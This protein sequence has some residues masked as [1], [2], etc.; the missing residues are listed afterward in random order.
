MWPTNSRASATEPAPP[1]DPRGLEAMEKSSDAYRTISEAA[2]ELDLPQHVLRFWETRFPQ[3]RPLKRGGG[4][5]F[6]RPDDLDLLRAIRHLLYGE[7]YTIRGVQKMLKEQGP[8][9]VIAQAL[10]TGG[11]EGVRVAASAAAS[12]AP[13]PEIYVDEEEDAE[14]DVAPAP[15]PMLR[16][17]PPLFAQTPVTAPAPAPVTAP[18]PIPSPVAVSAPAPSL[19]LFHPDPEPESLRRPVGA[20]APAPATSYAPPGLVLGA[21]DLRRLESALAELE[22]CR[23]LLSAA[24]A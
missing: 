4:R 15:A 9:G 20:V 18:A 10:A 3:V 21:E 14:P 22:E 16:E 7:G 13:D 11:G 8:R 5:R 6:Y 17:E 2:E 24:A 19:P 23:R 1:E 12:R